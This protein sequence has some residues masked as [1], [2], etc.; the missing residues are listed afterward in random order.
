MSELSD[1]IKDHDVI[2]HGKFELA[3]GKVSDI[4]CDGKKITL[5][6]DGLWIA[7]PK[8]FEEL[9]AVAE[10][11]AVGGLEVGAVPIVSAM[12]YCAAPGRIKL[13]GFFVRKEP[14]GHGTK[15]FIE[16]PVEPGMRVAIVEDVT[17]TGFSAFAALKRAEDFGL[18][19]VVIGTIIDRS[20]GAREFF[21]R[22]EV[23]FVSLYQ[24]K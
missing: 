24:I 9:F 19:P 14:K 7:V 4:Y 13:K 1:F 3:S 11:D 8:L 23:P 20:E 17:T 22:Q 15:K 18:K 10:F 2:Q 5:D 21:A 12:L 16:G 6:S